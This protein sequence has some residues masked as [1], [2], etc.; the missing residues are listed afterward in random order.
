ME[1]EMKMLNRRDFFHGLAAGAAW[2]ALP[3]R[4]AAQAMPLRVIVPASAG[5]GQDVMVRS[6]QQAMT[7]SLGRP[8]VVE[9]LPGSGGIIGTQRLVSSPPDGNTIAFVSNNHAV[10]PAVYKKM[11]YD[12]Q[13]D[14][15]PIAVLAETPFLLVVNS[16]RL[17]AS[18]ANEVVRLL[19]ARPDEYNFGSSG[20]GTIL[21]LAAEMFL[22]AAGAKARHVP[23][24]GTGPM[25]TDLMGGQIDF[26]V[27]AVPAVQSFLM[28]GTLTAVA[29]TGATRVPS[30]PN[31]PT[32]REQAIDVEIGGWLVAI[33]PAKLPATEVQRLHD[34][35]VSAWTSS[36]V[37]KAM[38]EQENLLRPSTAAEA[39]AFLANE[40][41]RFARLVRKV[42]VQ[43]D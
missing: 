36:E 29:A 33:G 10:N 23:Y 43:V 31:L 6:A 5:S 32:L 27:L 18:N 39:K 22:D 21:H 4:A 26:A 42:G 2:A 40:Q 24:K 1:T 11:P 19:K 13:K 25:I 41:E 38:A 28:A 3:G 12:S 15:T 14:V 34:G 20:N 30:I 17:A 8:V 35:I 7:K 16:K 9:N 37:K